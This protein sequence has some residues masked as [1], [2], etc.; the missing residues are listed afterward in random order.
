MKKF[1]CEAAVAM[2]CL[3]QVSD[4]RIKPEGWLHSDA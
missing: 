4:L 1:G 2:K 3:V